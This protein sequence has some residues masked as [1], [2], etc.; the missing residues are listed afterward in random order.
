VPASAT[1]V[2]ISRTHSRLEAFRGWTRA[3][4]DHPSERPRPG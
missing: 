1:N 4:P 3:R 2:R